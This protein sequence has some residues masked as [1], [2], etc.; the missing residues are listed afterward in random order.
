MCLVKK[1]SILCKQSCIVCKKSCS[2]VKSLVCFVKSLVCFLSRALKDVFRKLWPIFQYFL[3]FLADLGEIR[4]TG[5]K[6]RPRSPFCPGR[7]AENFFEKI[8]VVP[9]L[10]QIWIFNNRLFFWAFYGLSSQN[11][12]S[13]ELRADLISLFPVLISLLVQILSV[14]CH[15]FRRRSEKKIFQSSA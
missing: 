4:H 10:L 3:G 7:W 11:H 2:F 14:L 13:D 5:R 8:F 15:F 6:Y 1:S 9:L 12:Y